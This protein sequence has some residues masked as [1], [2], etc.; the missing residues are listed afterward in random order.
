MTDRRVV[1]GYLCLLH[2]ECAPHVLASSAEADG[3][4]GARGGPLP[5]P[6]ASTAWS[7]GGGAGFEDPA[8]VVQGAGDVGDD[9]TQHEP[10]VSH[11]SWE[12]RPSCATQAIRGFP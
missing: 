1:D 10:M 3:Q 8:L 2:A 12:R 11:R 5:S 6:A 9:G 7:H 4:V